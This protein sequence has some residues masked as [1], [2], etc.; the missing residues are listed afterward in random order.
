MIKT[1]TD[2]DRLGAM[3][4]SLI[5]LADTARFRKQLSSS[6]PG[7]PMQ[8]GF[9]ERFNR[10]YCEAVLDCFCFTVCSP[11]VFQTCDIRLRSRL[12]SS[13]NYVLIPFDFFRFVSIVVLTLL[14]AMSVRF[15]YAALAS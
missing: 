1:G 8:N 15:S 11:R 13:L 5:R 14:A 9:I 2:G 6:K 3:L 10:S 4:S 7:R 12:L